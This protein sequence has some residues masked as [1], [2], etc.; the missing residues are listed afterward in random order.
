MTSMGMMK[1]DHRSGRAYTQVELDFIKAHA[2]LRPRALAELFNA[3]FDRYAEP[4]RMSFILRK[5]GIEPNVRIAHKYTDEERRWLTENV[6]SMGET[7]ITTA[8]N[9]RFGTNLGRDTLRGYVKRFIGAKRTDET[10]SRSHSESQIRYHAGDLSIQT[11]GR[12]PIKVIRIED[13]GR[14]KWIPYGRYLWEQE[15]GKLPNGWVVIYLNNDGTDCR[16]ENIYAVSPDVVVLMA[17]NQWFS[18]NPEVTLT[19][20]KLCE[21]ARVSGGAIKV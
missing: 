14:L 20:L 8:F 15:H 6:P 17:R 2:D 13:N 9:A 7:E 3:T 12:R 21:L 16:P 5:M 4:K 11:R 1:I 10:V 18:Q 19:A